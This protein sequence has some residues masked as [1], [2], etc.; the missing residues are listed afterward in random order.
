VDRNLRG[1]LVEFSW[2]RQ[3]VDQQRLEPVDSR[4]PNHQR[5]DVLAKWIFSVNG[6]RQCRL[7]FLRALFEQL[8]VG[9]ERPVT[10]LDARC[11]ADRPCDGSQLVGVE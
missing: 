9:C 8:S 3:S 1:I 11:D 5:A 4:A 2:R 6:R 10:G 7:A